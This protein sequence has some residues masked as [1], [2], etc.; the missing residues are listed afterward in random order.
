MNL[1]CDENVKH[2]IYHLLVQ[3]GH[4]VARVQDHPGLG[5]DDD[6]IVEYCRTVG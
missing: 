1:L 2:S 4:D 3:E 5:F 6:D